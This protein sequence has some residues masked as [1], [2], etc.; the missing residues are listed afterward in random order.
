MEQ[1]RVMN[2]TNGDEINISFENI[3]EAEQWIDS[4]DCPSMYQIME[5]FSK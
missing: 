1:I 3:E 4:Q 2:I 5:D